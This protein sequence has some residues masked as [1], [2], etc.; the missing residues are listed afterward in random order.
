MGLDYPRNQL[1]IIVAS[2]CSTDETDAIVQS[3]ESTGVRL[4]RSPQRNGKEAAQKLAVQAASGE[5][6]I[7]SRCRDH[8]AAECDQEHCKKFRRSNRRVCQQRG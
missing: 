3:Y 8:F 2:D 7:F 4:I 5:I 6:L 1:D